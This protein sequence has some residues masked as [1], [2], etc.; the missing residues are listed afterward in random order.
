MLAGEG[1]GRP[2]R[3][4]SDRPSDP[5]G[6]LVELGACSTVTAARGPQSCAVRCCSVAEEAALFWGPYDGPQPHGAPA[7]RWP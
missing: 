7:T 6:L 3:A 5:A 4:P 2:A 1:G